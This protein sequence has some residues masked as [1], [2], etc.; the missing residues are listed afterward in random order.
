METELDIL[1]DITQ[2][3]D[4]AGVPYMLTGSMAMSHY[5]QPRM[6]RDIDL[7][8]ELRSADAPRL[9]AFLTGDYYVSEEAAV[10]AARRRSMFNAI[11]F[12]SSI[13]VDLIILPDSPFAREERVT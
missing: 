1:R 9:A 5:A 12:R 3:L 4:A 13:K 10:D 6:T 7:V 2:R 8:I 11:H